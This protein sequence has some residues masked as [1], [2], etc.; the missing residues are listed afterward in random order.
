VNKDDEAIN[1]ILSHPLDI[2]ESDIAEPI[3]QITLA[4]E[5]KEVVDDSLTEQKTSEEQA[6][7]DLQP[8]VPSTVT[9]TLTEDEPK[10]EEPQQPESTSVEFP[11]EDAQQES[12]P[13]E[14]EPELALE[15]ADKE[16]HPDAREVQLE[17]TL[18]E[19]Q[20]EPAVEELQQGLRQEFQPESTSEIQEEPKLE[21]P[22][23]SEVSE[24]APA[25]EEADEELHPGSREVQLEPTL[26]ECQQEPA[27]ETL[28]E[29]KLEEHH[30]ES[31]DDESEHE[32]ESKELHPSTTDAPSQEVDEATRKKIAKKEKK[33]G[34]RLARA[35]E[36]AAAAAAAAVAAE[37]A[38]ADPVSQKDEVQYS[39]TA[40][41]TSHPHPFESTTDA[42]EQENSVPEV[43]GEG[44]KFGPSTS[45]IAEI[46][47]PPNELEAVQ[48]P[49]AV[50]SIHDESAESTAAAAAAETIVPDDTTPV[51]LEQLQPAG[52]VGLPIE[53]QSSM[54]LVDQ[55]EPEAALPAEPAEGT[56][57]E[58]IEE[59]QESIDP[60]DSATRQPTFVEPR[61]VQPRK[62]TLHL[63]V[64]EVEHGE[65]SASEYEE[66]DSDDD[67]YDTS[68]IVSDTTS[69]HGSLHG[70]ARRSRYPGPN[71]ATSSLTGFEVTA[72]PH[73]E[74]HAHRPRSKKKK[75]KKQKHKHKRKKSKAGSDP[76]SSLGSLGESMVQGDGVHNPPQTSETNL[77]GDVPKPPVE[78]SVSEPGIAQSEVSEKVVP[79][80]RELVGSDSVEQGTTDRGVSGEPSESDV[81]SLPTLNPIPEEAAGEEPEAPQPTEPTGP[82]E[83][84]NSEMPRSLEESENTDSR[85]INE[86]ESDN[87]DIPS[88]AAPVPLEDDPENAWDLFTSSWG[89]S[90]DKKHESGHMGSSTE[91]ARDGAQTQ[92]RADD[93]QMI[94]DAPLVDEPLEISTPQRRNSQTEQQISA[95]ISTEGMNSE[96]VPENAANLDNG[97]ESSS[98]MLSEKRDSFASDP[99]SPNERDLKSSRPGS[100]S[101]QGGEKP[102]QWFSGI[103]GGISLISERFGGPKKK[104]RDRDKDPIP[105]DKEDPKEESFLGNPASRKSGDERSWEINRV[106]T[107]DDFLQGGKG[108]T[109]PNKRKKRQHQSIRPVTPEGSESI[110]EPRGT[111][112]GKE[113][114]RRRDVFGGELIESPDLKAAT[115]LLE[116][117]GPFELLRRNSQ[118][119]DPIGGLLREASASEISVL[120]PMDLSEFSDY[121]LSDYRLSPPRALPAV[122]EL[123]E[124]EAEA[125]ATASEVGFYRDSGFSGSSLPSRSR[126]HSTSTIPI[127]EDEEKQR[128]SGVD[129]DWVEAAMAQLKTPEP[130]NRTPERPPQR[131]LRRSTLGGQR[132]RDTTSLRDAALDSERKTIPGTRERVL[133][134]TG[135]RP[136]TPTG[137][138]SPTRK[139]YGA[140]AGMGIASRL[141]SGRASPTPASTERSDTPPA[142][143]RAA[144]LPP[145]AG[146]LRSLRR[147]VSAQIGPGLQ[148]PESPSLMPIPMEQQQQ[149]R[150]V[151]DSQIPSAT[152]RQQSDP[153]RADPSNGNVA[154]QSPPNSGLVRQR[155]PERLKISH[156]PD[157][158]SGSTVRSSSNPTPPLLRRADKRGADLRSLRQQSTSSATA[159]PPSEAPVANEGRARAKDKT[160]VYV[161]AKDSS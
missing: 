158:V 30:H 124:P 94:E 131:R 103:T 60:A 138:S 15:E 19:G 134:G 117:L 8:E 128:D 11:S 21:E 28:E 88:T 147:A 121:E 118:V 160:D 79:E 59:L 89:K 105:T 63:V 161:S 140:I 35:A 125:E 44:D 82:P 93:G 101:S 47:A 43:P 70:G 80:S 130:M 153:A 4:E 154:P 159:S 18:E 109:T 57:K 104:T 81:V 112:V 41:G 48:D 155:T 156:Q 95:D 90:G 61:D 67:D 74:Q 6:V 20:Q 116:S 33:K 17:P 13:E 26:E 96:N 54:Q 133:T 83:N 77:E 157:A 106:Q 58:L 7:N 65:S 1:P 122:E 25:L 92:E 3:P 129:G 68:T 119:A 86:S 141:S 126:R 127:E 142:L 66:S 123:P 152:K 34:R 114:T 38:V 151:S 72:L 12:K 100:A 51:D 76:S 53:E 102:N 120:P 111:G 69:L 145:V 14:L 27:S 139:G 36:A 40:D 50:E 39:P 150:S 22:L 46:D 108:P 24:P 10:F 75:K 107:I 73:G 52:T 49:Q 23:E 110:L 42:A 144:T 135:T 37:E 97:A 64:P 143:R 148:R 62:S 132:L 29:S 99:Q 9:D 136:E 2:F 98:G 32:S 85:P 149:P 56:S 87:R 5:D 71:D 115:E 146:P 31:S 45:D 113:I 137:R 91:L 55:P 16:L 84:K 78:I